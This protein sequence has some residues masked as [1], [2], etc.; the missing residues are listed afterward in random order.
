MFQ[1]NEERAVEVWGGDLA[2]GDVMMTTYTYTDIR[3]FFRSTVYVNASPDQLQANLA[4]VL[5]R[6]QVKSIKAILWGRDGER[7]REKF[8]YG[9]D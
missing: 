3:T 8:E 9:P 4:M 6:G 7:E 2:D 1:L 5:F